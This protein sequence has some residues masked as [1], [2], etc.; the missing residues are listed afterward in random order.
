MAVVDDAAEVVGVPGAVGVVFF[1]G[2]LHFGN[3]A[4][5]DFAVDE[6][7]VLGD[8]DLACVYDFAP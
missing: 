7:V 8:A 1:H 5:E 2:E 3:E 4:V 6:G